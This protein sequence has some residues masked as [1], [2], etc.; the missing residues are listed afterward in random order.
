[1]DRIATGI[2]GELPL[3]EKGNRYILVIS[4]YFTK[5]TDNLAMR[6]MEAAIVPRIIVEEVVVHYGTPSI[7]T[8]TRIVR[9][10]ASCSPRCAMSCT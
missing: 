4:D 1:M 10:R 6:N 2:L 9:T 7:P 8:M 3:T 5:L